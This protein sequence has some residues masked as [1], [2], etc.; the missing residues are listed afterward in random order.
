[1]KEDVPPAG[2][3]L[4]RAAALGELDRSAPEVA[5]RLKRDPELARAVEEL[6]RARTATEGVLRAGA[7]MIR[8]ASESATDA[9][10]MRVHETFQVLARGGSKSRAGSRRGWMVLAGLAA[11]ALLAFLFVRGLSPYRVRT[12]VET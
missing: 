5:A 4:L 1:M 11:A 9:D 6:E 3:E 2:E 12:D 10:R 7:S 8:A